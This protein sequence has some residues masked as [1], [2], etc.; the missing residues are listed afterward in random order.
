MI[1]PIE[2]KLRKLNREFDELL[3]ITQPLPTD[4]RLDNID[5]LILFGLTTDEAKAW[6]K[7]EPSFPSDA[8]Y[9]EPKSIN[10]LPE[11]KKA[12]P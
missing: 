5:R 4:N 1:D 7:K 9:H 3:G 8:S 2:D 12:T 11:P 6:L 10:K